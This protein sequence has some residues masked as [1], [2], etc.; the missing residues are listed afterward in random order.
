MTSSGFVARITCFAVAAT[1]VSVVNVHAQTGACCVPNGI[2]RLTDATTCADTFGG[3]YLGDGE[4]CVAFLCRGGCCR[5]DGTCDTNIPKLN[6]ETFG[7]VYQGHG[8]TCSGIE[9]PV[10]PNGACCHEFF[11]NEIV[12]PDACMDH[13][14]AG[15]GSTCDDCPGACCLA[16]DTCVGSTRGE[17]CPCSPTTRAECLAIEGASFAGN[18]TECPADGCGQ[19]ACCFPS[20]TGDCAGPIDPFN[21]ARSDGVYLGHCSLD[22]DRFHPS[23][24]IV[25]LSQLGNLVSHQLRSVQ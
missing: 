3:D 13:T 17:V 14:Y 2:C 16:G 4:P 21:C 7:G 19:G 23:K 9:C 15:D 24:G 12:T 11:C 6:C 18:L 22:K 5:P 8:S 25:F 10:L 1:L 20:I